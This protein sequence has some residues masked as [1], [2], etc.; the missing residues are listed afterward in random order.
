MTLLLLELKKTPPLPSLLPSPLFAHK[1]MD[2]MRS[3]HECHREKERKEEHVR[4]EG[5]NMDRPPRPR[6]C[7][8]HPEQNERESEREGTRRR[9]S[10]ASGI[11]SGRVG[12]RREAERRHRRRHA[13]VWSKKLSP[14]TL[15]GNRCRN[16]STPH[17]GVETREVSKQLLIQALG[18]AGFRSHKT[19]PISDPE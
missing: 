3:E 12:G 5:K 15:T 18:P 13:T 9:R 2:G 16:G 14:C 7:F 19:H 17:T 1:M 8:T 4:K 11:G 6:L 10:I